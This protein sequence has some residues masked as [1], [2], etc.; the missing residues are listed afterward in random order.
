MEDGVVQ[1]TTLGTPQ[2]GVL[3][4]DHRVR[5]CPANIALNFLDWHLDELGDRF[6]RYADDFVVLCRTELQAK[7]AWTQ[8]GQFLGTL[9]LSLSPT[10]T[11][12]TTF[13]K[14]F[15]FLGFDVTSHSVKM[16]AKSLEN[17]KT[18]V[19]EITTRSHN[20][21]AEAVTK[22]NS[23]MRGVER[24]FGTWFSTCVTQFRELDEWVRMRLR[25]QKLKRQ[26]R[27]HHCRIKDA[28]LERLGL[29]TLSALHRHSRKH[30]RGC[31]STEAIP[32]SATARR[33]ANR[34]AGPPS[35]RK[36]HAGKSGESTPSRQR[37]GRGSPLPYPLVFRNWRVVSLSCNPSPLPANFEK[38]NTRPQTARRSQWSEAEPRWSLRNAPAE[39]SPFP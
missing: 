27:T 30:V 23:V 20:L 34:A 11:H 3:S 35:A 16:R 10:K 1:T 29:V 32:W 33:K 6:V 38:P 18:K 13:L 5:R 36:S 15:T 12:V 24:D 14:G 37:G 28:K 4:P 31:S 21:D 7:E 8:I 39:E 19:K 2:G 17:F 26:S 25:C 9:G 22:L